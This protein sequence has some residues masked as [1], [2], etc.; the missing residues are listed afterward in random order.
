[1]FRITKWEQPTARWSPTSRA[2]AV[3]TSRGGRSPWSQPQQD[4]RADE[5]R[6]HS[7]GA[8]GP[9]SPR[10]R[11]GTATPDRDDNSP[12]RVTRGCHGSRAIPFRRRQRSRASARPSGRASRWPQPRAN[13][14]RTRWTRRRRRRVHAPT[15]SAHARGHTD[16][17]PE[18]VG[19]RSAWPPHACSPALGFRS[20][21]IRG[22]IPS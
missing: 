6:R 21:S 11:G 7:L 10:A 13:A 5:P 9:F 15:R 20:P 3:P 14:H 2:I 22:R 18:P 1:M 4:V 16:C 19:E 8:R 17:T 12:S